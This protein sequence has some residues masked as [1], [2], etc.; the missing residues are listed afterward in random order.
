MSKYFIGD[1]MVVQAS[2]II[3]KGEEVVNID[4][5]E[6]NQGDNNDNFN[7]TRMLE[8]ILD[9]EKDNEDIKHCWWQVTENYHP[10]A[11]VLERDE[12]QKYLES[13]YNFVCE[14][15]ACAK[16]LPTIR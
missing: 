13:S 7:Y 14:C 15:T 10:V 8:Q 16:N 4:Y 1:L 9:G 5:K 3:K 6:E 2:K 11:M 12:R